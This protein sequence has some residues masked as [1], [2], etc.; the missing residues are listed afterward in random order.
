MQPDLTERYNDGV[1]PAPR[2]E[3]EP[4]RLRPPAWMPTPAQAQFARRTLKRNLLV[5]TGI[6]ILIGSLINW[7]TR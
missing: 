4:R 5:I 1:V 2:L 6:L 7:L 3:A